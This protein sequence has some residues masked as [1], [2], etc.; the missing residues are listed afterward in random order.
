MATAGQSLAGRIA[1]VTGGAGGI[2]SAI[3]HLLAREGA[4]LIVTYNSRAERAHALVESLEGEGHLVLPLSVRCS[5]DIVAAAG[6]VRERYG[7]LHLLVNNAGTTRVVPHGDL[8]A[9]DDALIDEIFQTNW[10]GAFAMV[11][12]FRPLLD[13]AGEALVV[14]ISSIAGVTAVGSNVAYCASKAALDSMT[15][16]L[17]RAL[18][19]KIR[20]VSVSPGWVMG[21]YA[22]SADPAYLARQ[23]ELTPLGRIAEAGDVAQ[24]VLAAATLLGFTNGAI[25]PVDGGRPLN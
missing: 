14:N 2:G 6:T 16:A 5:E 11:R 1:L 13:A 18:A 15:K 19:P 12:G 10:R 8:N 17:A 22:K 20:V 23:S 7:C 3:C 25:I 21:D 24:A 9:L 4:R